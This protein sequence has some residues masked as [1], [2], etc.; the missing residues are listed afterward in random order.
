MSQV[1]ARDGVLIGPDHSPIEYHAHVV[2][3]VVGEESLAVIAN[4][5]RG[6]LLRRL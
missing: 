5:N 6:V 4:G 2:L 3:V 1:D